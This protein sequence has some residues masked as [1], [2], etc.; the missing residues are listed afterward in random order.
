MKRIKVENLSKSYGKVR[1][2]NNISFECSAG[3]FITVLGSPGAGKTTLL[4]SIAGLIDIDHGRVYFDDLDVTDLD[5]KVRN[6][7][8]AFESYALY[9]HLTVRE[10]ILHPLK[11][12]GGYTESQMQSLL[13]EVST[14]LRITPLM[15]RKT[16]QLS[17]GQRQRVGLA[18]A[19]IREKPN[20]LL[21]DEPIAHLDASLRHWLRAELKK[22]I[23]AKGITTIYATPDYLEALAMG[24]RVLV[25]SQ[26]HLKQMGSPDDVLYN[27][28]SAE[29]AAVIGDPPANVL[30]ARVVS[31]EGKFVIDLQGNK[32]RAPER[33]QSILGSKKYD[34]IIMGIKPSDITILKQRGDNSIE[35]KV[36]VTEPLQRKKVVTLQVGDVQVKVNAPLSLDVDIEDQVYANIDTEKIM[37]FDPETREAVI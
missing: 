37:L 34:K 13:E 26:G 22:H 11:I 21:L 1:A 31:Y 14:M 5:P 7:S 8:M 25:L 30:E 17:G 16:S 23:K 19:L 10:N 2:L 33:Y 35:A 36:Y 4:K 15:D 18:R 24:D 6:V 27:P 3:E 28:S 9:P 29:V 20:L 32:I 12:R